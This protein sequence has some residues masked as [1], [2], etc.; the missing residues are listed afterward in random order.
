MV[1]GE[2]EAGSLWTREPQVRL[3][4]RTLGSQP[5]PKADT[6]PTEP[7]RRPIKAPFTE[8]TETDSKFFFLR[9]AGREDLGFSL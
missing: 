5:E 1:E 7:P 4:P 3:H 6:H 2:G 9:E 8:D